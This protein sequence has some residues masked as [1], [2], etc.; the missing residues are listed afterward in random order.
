ML[1]ERLP[2]LRNGYPFFAL[3]LSPSPLMLEMLRPALAPMLICAFVLNANM[4][5]ARNKILFMAYVLSGAKV[6]GCGAGE[7]VC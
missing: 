3:K 6:A 5:N 7:N 1:K 2:N 4:V